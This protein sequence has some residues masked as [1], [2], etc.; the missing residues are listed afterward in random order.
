MTSC[1]VIAL[2]RDALRRDALRRHRVATI[3]LCDVMRCDVMRCDV[4]RCD[5]SDVSVLI[6]ALDHVF[7]MSNFW[8]WFSDF[9]KRE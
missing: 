5:V 4:M 1:D 2:R 7:S 9:I 8:V 3:S 6:F